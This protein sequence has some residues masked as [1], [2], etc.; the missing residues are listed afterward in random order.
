MWERESVMASH[1][2]TDQI[3]CLYL[4]NLKCTLKSHFQ[5][6]DKLRKKST[7]VDPHHDYLY[8]KGLDKRLYMWYNSYI[9]TLK[10]ECIM[11]STKDVLIFPDEEGFTRA[12]EIA[13]GLEELPD[14]EDNALASLAAKMNL[15]QALG[16]LKLSSAE[17][18]SL[19]TLSQKYIP[20]SPK[21][22]DLKATV[23][24]ESIIMHWLNSNDALRQASLSNTQIFE[25]EENDRTN[26]LEGFTELVLGEE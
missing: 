11:P 14:L 16:V 12:K 9:I 26:Q 3:Q 2:P 1:D 25:V 7:P 19:K 17:A 4:T 5:L 15:A 18:A 10:Q 23:K 6:L 24:T 21:R 13:A 22:I 20:D 8:T